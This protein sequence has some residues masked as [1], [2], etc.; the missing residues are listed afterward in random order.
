[1][2]AP[3]IPVPITDYREQAKKIF[4]SLDVNETTRQDYQYR[5]GAFADFVI[6][7]GFNRN[8]FLEFKRY[9]GGRTDTAVATKNKY[10]ASARIFL[11]ELNRLGLIQ[12]DITQNVKSFTQ[13]KKH[14]RDGLNGEEMQRLA[15]WLQQLPPTPPNARLKAIISLLALQGLR[16]I[17]I[18]RLDVKDLDIV[19]KTAFVQGK[20]QADKELIHLHPET[21]KT[22][23]E[24][25]KSN[26]IADGALFISRSNNSQRQRL[27]TRGLRKIV[28][29]VL[30]YLS[31]EKTVHG[32]RHYFTTTLISTYKG[33]LLDVMQ[34]TRHK[35]VDTLQIYNDK[36][37]QKADLPRFYN[38]FSKLSF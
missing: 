9:L 33:D 19:N 27:T 35:S 16:Q 30:S 38:T 17:E 3:I 25:L 7:R 10:L 13:S 15:N 24:Y 5:I 36:V 28:Q 22:L 12:T 14:K 26:K 32:F 8:S 37:R 31:V 29:E 6:S 2:N 21:A 1:M 18:T 11:K 4:E 20:G 34:Y 23:Q